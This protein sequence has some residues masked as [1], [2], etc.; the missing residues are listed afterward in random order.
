MNK[1]NFERTGGPRGDECSSYDVSFPEGM[2]LEEL[3]KTIL[4]ER[5]NEWGDIK[6][7]WGQ[8]PLIEYSKGRLYNPHSSLSENLNKEVIKIKADGGWSLMTYILELKDP[9]PK[10]DGIITYDKDEYWG[11]WIICGH[12]QSSHT[13]AGSNYCCNCGHK[14]ENLHRETNIE[15]NERYRKELTEMR[16]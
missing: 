7:G 8:S 5:P 2:T 11:Q 9:E 1:L 16:D 12:C 6:L 13:P 3:I 10:I 4:E 14:F 15:W